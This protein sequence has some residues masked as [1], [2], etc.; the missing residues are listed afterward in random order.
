MGKI[1]VIVAPSGSGKSTLIQRLR[2]DFPNL[3]ESIS[4]TTRRPRDGEVDGIHYNFI[5]EDDFIKRRDKGEFLEWAQVH[6]NYYGTSKHFVEKSLDTGNDLLFDLDVQGTDSF[7]KYFGE[8]AQA[9]F[10]A[11][12]SID[13]LEKRLR[14]RGTDDLRTI[15]LRIENSKKEIKRKDDYDFC[16]VN[17]ELERAYSELKNV[18]SQILTSARGD[19]V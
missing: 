19:N 12:P 6:S 1:I 11:P 10:I 3:S 8:R 16:I 15:E 4:Y 7:K 17:D 14:A 18:V 2:E 9:I 13:E 5:Q